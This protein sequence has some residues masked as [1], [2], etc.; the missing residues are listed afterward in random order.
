[1]HVP[2]SLYALVH[3]IRPSPASLHNF[4]RH[5]QPC[6]T[7]CLSAPTTVPNEISSQQTSPPNTSRPLN[8]RTLHRQKLAQPLQRLIRFSSRKMLHRLE[9]MRCNMLI[10]IDTRRTAVR[11]GLCG[12]LLGWVRRVARR[13]WSCGREMCGR[14][15]RCCCCLRS[16]S[17]WLCGDGG[18]EGGLR[19]GSRRW[20]WGKLRAWLIVLFCI[21]R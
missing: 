11:Y 16:G 12:R 18:L 13:C 8:L 17:G 2:R 14:R 20:V 7:S 1:M 4:P 10:Q 6:T 5:P 21:D 3:V 15:R 19:R 9:Q